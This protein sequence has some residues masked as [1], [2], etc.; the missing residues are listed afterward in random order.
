MLAGHDPSDPA[1]ANVPVGDYWGAL[2]RDLSGLVVGV[3][4]AFYYERLDPEIEAAARA[5][6]ASLEK[7]GA[8]LVKV[9]LPSMEH[10]RTVSL[11]VQLPEA[12]SYHSR[13][14]EDR[15]ELYGQ[16]FRAGLALGQCL[17][18]EHY[19]RAKR[20]IELYRQQTNAVLDEVDVL[21]TPG[22]PVI[23]PTRGTVKIT[24]EGIDEAVGNA[25]TRY[26]SF[27]NMT[28]HPAITLATASHSKG[29]PMGV[30]VVARHY[31]EETLFAVAAE[32][33]RQESF[34]IPPPGV[35]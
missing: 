27:F 3:P 25:V 24:L 34:R 32:I 1:C 13:Y 31:G 29:L 14:L 33:E 23:A 11:T 4:E 30:Q 17:L 26:T 15:G 12:L 22:A 2:K 10:A 6:L 8:T 21:I 16:D 20:F 5:V 18:A 7:A 35:E 9:R 19:V 28:G